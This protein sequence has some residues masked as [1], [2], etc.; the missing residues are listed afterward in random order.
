MHKRLDDLEDFKSLTVDDEVILITN[1]GKILNGVIDS[2][3]TNRGYIDLNEVSV[4]VE[5]LDYNITVNV[6]KYLKGISSLKD[7]ILII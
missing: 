7:F 2:V 4:Y 1:K 6:D 5:G 3:M